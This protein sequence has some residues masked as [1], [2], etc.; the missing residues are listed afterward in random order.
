VTCPSFFLRRIAGA[1][2]R[3]GKAGAEWEN[4]L[5]LGFLWTGQDMAKARHYLDQA[6]GAARLL[7]DRTALGASLNRIGNWRLNMEQSDEALRCHEEA[8]A[9]FAGLDDAPG[10]ALTH[11]LLGITHMIRGDY[12]ASI[13]RHDRAIEL[14][15]QTDDRM[16][17]ASALATASLRGGCYQGDVCVFPDVS[18]EACWQLG[19]EAIQIARQIGWRSD[20]ANANVFLALA[21]G[22][23]GAY[24]RSLQCARD[25]LDI[26]LDIGA[27]WEGVAHIPFGKT[28]HDCMSFD[29]ARMHFEQAAAFARRVGA[30][31]FHATAGS[32]LASN[33]IAQGDVQ[34]AQ[35]LLNQ[36]PD[37]LPAETQT[38]SQRLVACARAE[39][40]LATRNWPDALHLIDELKWVAPHVSDGGIV[41]RLWLL[42]AEALARLDR[43]DEACA[44]LAEAART[45]Q[46]GSFKPILWRIQIALG[47][48]LQSQRRHAEALSQ[49]DHARAVVSSL[50][51]DL[52][53]DRLR[54][55]LESS[56]NA[57]IAT[58]KAA[59]PRQSAKRVFDGLTAREREV[60]ALVAPAG[61]IA[62]SG[63]A[64]PDN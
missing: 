36:L 42:R 63:S 26:A 46:A 44:V 1:D 35:T 39:L 16:S 64:R 3:H 30:A 24:A 20:E 11:D 2:S 61:P 48:I 8:L 28:H 41:P 54:E 31:E 7:G 4:L 9:T 12:P 47:R 22:A 60:T 14:F 37:M 25:G 62:P 51:A 13:P 59:A 50:A 43:A 49:L 5:S 56:V 27:I 23:R 21:M 6:L 55:S 18:V 10:V 38:T 32:F 34:A 33:M 57:L 17:L 52:P 29:S 19:A 15:R 40:L 58:P 45:A 53:D